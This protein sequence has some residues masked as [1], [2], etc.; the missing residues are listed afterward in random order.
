ML[1]AASVVPRDGDVLVEASWTLALWT[2]ILCRWFAFMFAH[3]NG[4]I[5]Y[6]C[7][8]QMRSNV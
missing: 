2:S 4:F 3:G 8:L 5:G 6:H 7:F 1:E